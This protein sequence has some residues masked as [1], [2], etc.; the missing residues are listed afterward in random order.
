MSG[1]ACAAPLGNLSGEEL[2]RVYYY[3][4]FPSTLLSLHPDYVMVH[5]LWPRSVGRT[6]IT[7]E[8]LFSPEALAEPGFDAHDAIDFWDMTNRQD[9]A[10]CE[11]S[12]LGAASRAYSPAPY[13][14]A[15]SLLAAFDRELLRALGTGVQ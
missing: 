2:D 12:Q 1:R 9:W 7:C 11:I 13:S 4:I 6:Q 3:S 15:E 10:M 14:G 5:T 8:W